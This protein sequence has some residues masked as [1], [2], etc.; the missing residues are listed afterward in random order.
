MMNAA[1]LFECETIYEYT[2]HTGMVSFTT[3]LTLIE[4]NVALQPHVIEMKSCK[5]M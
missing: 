3:I 4:L 2:D 1:D 5:D